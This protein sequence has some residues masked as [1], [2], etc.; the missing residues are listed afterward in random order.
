MEALP[1]GGDLMGTLRI[2]YMLE[3]NIKVT[4]LYMSEI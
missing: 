4:C 3:K 1:P 2:A